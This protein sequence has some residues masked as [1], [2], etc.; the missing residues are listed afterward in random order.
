MMPE[1]KN[2]KLNSVW[3]DEKAMIGGNPRVDESV[4]KEITLT[5]K[6]VY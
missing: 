4:K 6:G 5:Y 2:K 3:T 1:I